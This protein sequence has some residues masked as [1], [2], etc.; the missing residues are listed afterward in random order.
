MLGLT[1]TDYLWNRN[2]LL[3]FTCLHAWDGGHVENGARRLSSCRA[4]TPQETS[5]NGAYV[6][7]TPRREPT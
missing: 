7:A 1:G 4:I 3:L 5:I 2:R 6:G